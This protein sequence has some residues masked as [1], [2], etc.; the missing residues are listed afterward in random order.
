MLK[1]DLFKL[2]TRQKK[3]EPR[4]ESTYKVVTDWGEAVFGNC[5][6]M[7]RFSLGLA[8][9][10]PDLKEDI[11]TTDR[12]SSDGWDLPHGSRQETEMI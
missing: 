3:E 11:K 7:M 9:L 12:N 8:F 10:V 5:V 6:S 4:T 2:V 1:G